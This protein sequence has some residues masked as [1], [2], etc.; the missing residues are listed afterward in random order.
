VLCSSPVEAEEATTALHPV[1]PVSGRPGECVR[2]IERSGAEVVVMVVLA[3]REGVRISLAAAMANV[4][5]RA[6][7]GA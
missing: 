4:G 7:E 3:R 6:R 1:A 2:D 5:N